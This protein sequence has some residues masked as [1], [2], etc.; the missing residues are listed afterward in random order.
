[1]PSFIPEWAT[2]LSLLL[3]TLSVPLA[4]GFESKYIN[5]KAGWKYLFPSIGI[6]MALFIPWDVA[7]T[8]HEVWGFNE[9]YLSGVFLFNLP[10]EEWLFF[11]VV[12]FACVFIYEVIHRFLPYY[13]P[14][15]FSVWL[16]YSLGILAFLGSLIFSSNWYTSFTLLLLS[17]FLGYS[18]YFEKTTFIQR[19][20]TTF[21]IVQLPFILVNGVLT[22]SWIEEPVV[23]YNNNENVGIRLLTIPIEDVAYNF[24]MLFM[25]IHFYERFKAKKAIA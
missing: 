21:L 3:F 25:V 24:L 1:M 7:F 2:Y 18:L 8:N 17:L 20:F 4:R 22:G 14:Q 13:L 23:W 6:M 11:I 19:F 10:I 12:P 15:N 9:R 16:G 5:Y